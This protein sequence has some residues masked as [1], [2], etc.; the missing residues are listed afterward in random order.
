MENLKKFLCVTTIPDVDTLEN[1]LL[2][3]YLKNNKIKV[4]DRIKEF[5]NNFDNFVK[6]EEK[7]NRLNNFQ[8]DKNNQNVIVKANKTA[9]LKKLQNSQHKNREAILKNSADLI[10]KQNQVYFKHIYYLQEV[11]K[12]LDK[13]NSF[14]TIH[15]KSDLINYNNF[16]DYNKENPNNYNE[17][18]YKMN[19]DS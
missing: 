16:D 13:I 6:C 10:K 18:N 17:I 8:N 9:E 19:I 2:E 7:I 3:N 5:A 15:K 4:S 11:D 12:L 1:P 14:K